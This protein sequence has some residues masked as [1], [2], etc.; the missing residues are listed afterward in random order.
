M[1]PTCRILWCLTLTIHRTARRRRGKRRRRRRRI[2]EEEEEEAQTR[3]RILWFLNLTF[4]RT[5]RR[6]RG[7]TEV[8]AAMYSV[9]YVIS[10]CLRPKG[11]GGKGE[12]GTG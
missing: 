5:A 6:R 10:G 2:S 11:P 12:G 4:H 8:L 1:M 3:C 9:V 7:K